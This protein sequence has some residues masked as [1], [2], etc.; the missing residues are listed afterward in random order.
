[1]LKDHSAALTQRT[2]HLHHTIKPQKSIYPLKYKLHIK[3]QKTN[4][5]RA[6]PRNRFKKPTSNTENGTK[7]ANPEAQKA[8]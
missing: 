6:N 2:H 8:N 7:L 3:Y 1:M 4:L 5:N